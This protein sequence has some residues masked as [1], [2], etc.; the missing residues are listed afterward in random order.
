M[1]KKTTMT[2]YK[3]WYWPKLKRISIESTAKGTL[4]DTFDTNSWI[5]RVFPVPQAISMTRAPLAHASRQS[6]WHG[7][8]G[9]TSP[10]SSAKEGSAALSLTTM[11]R[12]NYTTLGG[13]RL[14]TYKFYDLV[15][16]VTN[17]DHRSPTSFILQRKQRW[18]TQTSCKHM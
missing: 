8:S 10:V 3:Y 1:T 2:K 12:Q 13:K 11:L 7:R 17:W 18:C 4:P 5:T 16:R 15:L 9:C 6:R 14:I